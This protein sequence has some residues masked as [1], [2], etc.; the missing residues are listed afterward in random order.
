VK[1]QPGPFGLI[2][3]VNNAGQ[4]YLFWRARLDSAARLSIIGP[5]Q[6]FHN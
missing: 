1:M 5:N 3:S 2:E 6:V 4:N